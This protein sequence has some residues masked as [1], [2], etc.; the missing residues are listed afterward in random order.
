[1]APEPSF[2]DNERVAQLVKDNAGSILDYFVR[3]VP[4]REDAADLLGET[5]VVV[6]RKVGSVPDDPGEA[7]MWIFGVAR[8]V[9][10]QGW[11]SRARRRALTDKLAQHLAEL[12]PAMTGITPPMC[13][14][15]SPRS[16][17]SIR[18]S[19]VWSIG[20]ASH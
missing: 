4:D 2:T 15:R 16:R 12:V 19:S 18:R 6:W 20:M 11:R 5:L 10:S 14:L 13:V 7:R 3:R 9:L 1:M 17:R 8:P